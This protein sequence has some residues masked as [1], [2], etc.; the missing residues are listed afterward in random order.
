MGATPAFKPTSVLSL[1]GLTLPLTAAFVQ[2]KKNTV[3][4]NTCN[5][6]TPTLDLAAEKCFQRNVFTP[7]DSFNMTC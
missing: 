3:H 7:E 5:F 1:E 6:I 2:I 4:H